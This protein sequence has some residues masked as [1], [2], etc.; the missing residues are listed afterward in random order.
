MFKRD[1]ETELQALSKDYPIVTVLGPRQSGKTTLVRLAFPQ[2][3]YINLED[4]DVRDMALS[5]PRNFL[6]RLE[7]GAILDELQRVPQLL[8]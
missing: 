3:P 6:E 1:L 8:S 5:D 4:P 7:E 2:M